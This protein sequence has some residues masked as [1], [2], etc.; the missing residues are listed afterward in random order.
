[1]FIYVVIISMVLIPVHRFLP[2]SDDTFSFYVNDFNSVFN[3]GL[4]VMNTY[5]YL[6]KSLYCSPLGT[7]LIF[8]LGIEF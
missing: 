7:I 6:K 1:M 3:I 4:P 5:V 8:Q 2:S